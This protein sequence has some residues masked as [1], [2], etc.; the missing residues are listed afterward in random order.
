MFAESTEVLIYLSI[1]EFITHAGLQLK[2]LLPPSE[3]HRLM[4][5]L[6]KFLK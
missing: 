4:P 1:W 6:M 3:H 5:F 2:I